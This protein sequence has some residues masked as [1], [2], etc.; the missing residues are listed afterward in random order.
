MPN[1]L[2]VRYEVDGEEISL[3]PN[4]VINY[5]ID[6][7][8]MEN[9]S[10]K[11]MARIIMTL[12]ARN[13]NPFTGD[14]VIQP[15]KNKDGS[16][17]CSMVTT[18]DFF[19]RRAEANPRYR[20]KKAGVTVL[21]KDGRPVKRSGSAVYEQLGERLIGGWCEVYIEGHDHPEYA[22]V[23]LKEYDQG[24]A[25]WKTKPATMIRKVAV[26]QALRESF[27]ND[28]NGLYEPE[29]MG[30]EEPKAGAAISDV[31]EAPN[32]DGECLS[33]VGDPLDELREAMRIAAGYGV[34]IDDPEDPMRGLM[35]YIRATFKKEPA[36]L[37]DGELSMALNHVYKVISDYESM[38]QV[39]E[40]TITEEV[41]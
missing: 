41:F 17:S 3:N 34:I 38:N 36:Y 2:A 40:E 27:P 39:K 20:G 18:K 11:E 31:S 37:N 21:T 4:V 14:V 10:Q 22:E 24:Y 32:T 6:D 5:L 30:L 33:E 19:T 7:K 26:S 1:E 23:A 16:V 28:F 9:I 15:H 25:L 12:K 35:G 8:N 13:L 29:E